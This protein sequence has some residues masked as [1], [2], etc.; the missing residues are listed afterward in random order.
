MTQEASRQV[1]KILEGVHKEIMDLADKYR[2]AHIDD[3]WFGHAEQAAGCL[4]AAF[5]SP[6]PQPPAQRA[7]TGKQ[8]GRYED[9]VGEGACKCSFREAERREAA[10]AARREKVHCLLA[11]ALEDSGYRVGSGGLVVAPKKVCDLVS[12][13]G[14]RIVEMLDKMDY[15]KKAE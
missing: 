14:S 3:D 7:S 15:A 2:D 1:R 11:S 10:R 5:E 9:Y 8:P 12:L 6:I 13:L 4:R